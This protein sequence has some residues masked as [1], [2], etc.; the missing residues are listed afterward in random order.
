MASVLRSLPSNM[1]PVYD[2]IRQSQT[3]PDSIELRI[4]IGDNYQ[5]IR[6]PQVSNQYYEQLLRTK[7]VK[8]QP[9]LEYHIKSRMALNHHLLGNQDKAKD[10]FEECVANYLQSLD[11]PMQLFLLAKI[12]LLDKNEEEARKYLDMIRKEF[13]NDNHL[14]FTE[15]LFKK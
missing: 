7:P 5:L 6:M 15:D 12:N 14:K 8:K 10:L 13:P 2:L 4:A 11:R 3:A 1:A 9:K